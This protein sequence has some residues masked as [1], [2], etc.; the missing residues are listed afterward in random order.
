[1]A[2]QHSGTQEAG[3]D[4]MVLDDTIK[5]LVKD[6]S[7][8]YKN[9][10]T[11]EGVYYIHDD[12]DMMKGY[13]MVIGPE[14]S[15]Y[16]HGFYFFEFT[17][18][19]NYPQSPPI[20]K[21]KTQDGKTRF[22]PNLYRNGKVCLSIINT[23]KGEGWTSCQT[24]RS[25]LMTILSILDEEPLLNEPGITKHNP[26]FEP[27]HKII[28]FRNYE[29]AVIKQLSDLDLGIKF[30]SFRKFMVDYY[31]DNRDKIKSRI[32]ALM[33]DS[34]GVHSYTTQIY[35][36]NATVNYEELLNSFSSLELSIGEI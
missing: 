14:G 7:S 1:M 19:Y 11:N 21:F 4:G 25:V 30:Q 17:F 9:P 33:N 3:T 34:D 26:S 5:R 24:I 16:E 13:A 20:V 27:Y 22:H 12:A 36:L 35:N 8:L 2:S 6:V 23:W 28:A 10:L 32:E 29:H 15:L 31:N 18:P